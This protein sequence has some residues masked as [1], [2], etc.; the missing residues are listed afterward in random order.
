MS[1][2]IR[3]ITDAG[4]EEWTRVWSSCDHATFFQ[5]PTWARVWS[6]YTR[7]RIRPRPRRVTFSD[8]KGA[9]LPLSVRRTMGG[10]IARHESSIA[11]T[12]GGWI[13]ADALEGAHARVLASYLRG[14][15]PNLTWRINPFDPH[16][17]AVVKGFEPDDTQAL[18]LETDFETIFRTWSKGHRAA[19]KQAEREGVSVRPAQSTED[20][21]AYYAAYEDSIRRWGGAAS[22]VYEWELFD[23]LSRCES[24]QVRLWL[25]VHDDRVIAGALCLYA[26]RHVSYWHGAALADDFKR[27]PVN[28][29]L[30]EA[31]RDACARGYHWFDFNPSGDNEGVR[32]F[33]S[34][35]GTRSFASGVVRTETALARAARRIAGMVRSR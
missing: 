18:V 6:A 23:Q 20:W 10:L 14:R 1:V 9:V 27:R 2:E 15:V 33:K 29:L 12:F 30:F 3:E 16:A 13:T 28:L 19:V 31:I 21:R 22:I 11:G 8:G 25:A 17:A 24:E 34:S 35:F 7:G 4:H 26:R 32:S 5:S